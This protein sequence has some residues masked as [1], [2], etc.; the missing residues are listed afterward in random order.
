MLLLYNKLERAYK[1]G[2]WD[3]LDI[4]Q[5]HDYNWFQRVQRELSN[6]MSEATIRVVLFN[7]YQISCG[8]R[9]SK[10]DVVTPDLVNEILDKKKALRA[11][12]QIRRRM[13]SAA[14]IVFHEITKEIPGLLF[15]PPQKSVEDIRVKRVFSRMEMARLL[16]QTY[17]CPYTELMMNMLFTTGVRIGALASIRW[18]QV[19][20]E[21]S[22]RQVMRTVVVLE[23][24]GQKRVLI[25]SDGVRRLLHDLAGSGTTTAEGRIFPWTSRTLRS[26][27][28]SACAEAGFTGSHCHPHTA[29]HSLVHLLFEEGNSLSLISKFMGHRNVSTTSAFYLRLSYDELLQQMHIPWVSLLTCDRQLQTK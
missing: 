18:S 25:L 26:K 16:S 11:F 7:T 28:R 23:K 5:R 8:L 14:N 10:L 4:H 17:A 22:T 21:A 1:T 12:P 2:T 27:F 13:V 20:Q 19:I 15:L 6:R 24:G 29:R 9:R 3:R